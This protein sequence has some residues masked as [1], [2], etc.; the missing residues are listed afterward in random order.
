MYVNI[1]DGI[2]NKKMI[3]ILLFPGSD[4]SGPDSNRR[5]NSGLSPIVEKG[6]GCYETYH[7]FKDIPLLDSLRPLMARCV[8]ANHILAC[9]FNLYSSG[10]LLRFHV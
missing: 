9:L 7:A 6:L 2:W 1:V 4:N 5:C 8:A 10:R 3:S